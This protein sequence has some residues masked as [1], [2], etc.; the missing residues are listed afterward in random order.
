[1]LQFFRNMFKSTVGAAV[2]LLVLG[3]IAF[4]FV[5][6]DLSNTGNIGLA[7]GG[8]RVATV[9]GERIDA[10]TLGQAATNAV[11][12]VKQQ[13]PTQS[14]QSFLA[15]GGLDRVLND[16][17]DRTALAA[18]GK[19]HGIIASDRLIDSEIAQIPAFKGPDGKFSETVFRQLMQQRGVS[20]D[21]VRNDLG[22]G[23][24]SRQ[25]LI[26]ASYGAVAPREAAL[27]YA[28]LL[29]EKRNGTIALLPSALFAPKTPPTDAQLT[30][31][32]AQKRSRF[33]RPE[34]R[35]IRFATF[36]DDAL[37]NLA[38]PTE[39]EITTSYNANKAQYA[40]LETRQVTQL[41]VPT[42][43]AARAVADEVAKGKALEAAASAKG[44]SAARLGAVGKDALAAQS[45]PAVA[46]AVFAA[47]KG[48][49][50]APAR[51][52]LG[53]HVIRVDS[54]D[55]R[56]ARSLESV[57]AELTTQIATTKRRQALNDLSA[58]LEDEFDKGGNLTEAARELG[59]TLQ[60]TGQLT[61]DG[62]VYGQAGARAPAVLGRTLQTA[63]AM[64]EN[65]PQLAEVEPGKTFLIFDVKDI[66]PSAPA[67]LA[68]I[69]QDVVVAYMLDRGATAAKTA[70]DKVQAEVRK[71]ATL[72]AAMAALGV[73]LPPAQ[74]IDMD[75]TQL[76]AAGRQ[77][78]P[79]L[80]LLF[81]M[82]EGTVKTL[83]APGGQGWF[84]VALKDIVPFPVQANDPVLPAARQ[85]LGQL[86]GEEYVQQLRRAIRVEVGAKRDEAGIKAVK[87]QLGGGSN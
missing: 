28:A 47:A 55:V 41:I 11:E 6:G 30:A 66:S 64:E 83:A 43:A 65:K 12:N 58:R 74:P 5:S 75:R 67:P 49:I 57:K 4:A 27:R 1:M 77:P 10:T 3:L 81:S 86:A 39:A 34:R 70:A 79:P 17:I 40:A 20:E 18:F 19:D 9:G 16:M 84:I 7:K 35:V 59:V 13:D 2:A 25:L 50:A 15:A 80:M 36:G 87:T 21:L 33:I 60:E 32:Y 31:F 73:P 71:G 72:P 14:M 48:A 82:A 37:K 85:Q 52:G 26:P 46:N 63:F 61:A 23:L 76:T 8:D 62:G 24:I 54:I 42:E 38:A 45:S 56:P 53:W 51:S 44:L 22:Q 29:R 68:E 78:P 69:K